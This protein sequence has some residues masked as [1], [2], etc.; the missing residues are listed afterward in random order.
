MDVSDEEWDGEIPEFVTKKQ[1]VVVGIPV[2]SVAVAA[3]AERVVKE[4]KKR[5]DESD[6]WKNP[7]IKEGK[8]VG[9]TKKGVWRRVP[10]FPKKTILVSSK[11]WV[12][13]W[14]KD[15]KAWGRPKRGT[16]RADYYLEIGLHGSLY[17]VHR[18][19]CR[20][21]RGAPPSR[22]HTTDHLAKYGDQRKERQDNRAENL[23]WKDASGQCN[24]RT[25]TGA[26][27]SDDRPLEVRSERA[28]AG[29]TPGEWTWFQSQGKAA[30]AMGVHSVSVSDWLAG[31]KRCSLGWRLR[32]APFAEPQDDLPATDEDPA[33][34]WVQVDATTR[35]SNHGR[36]EQPY[37][38]SEKKRKYTPRA[39]E[40]TG[41][42]PV[43]SVGGKP[44][45]YFHVVVFD[46][47]C[48]GV[49]G[50]RTVDHINR[51]PSDA[52]LSNLRPYTMAQQSRNRR[53]KPLGDGNQDSKKTRIQYRRADAPDDAPWQKCL[54]AHELA[55]RLTKTTKKTYGYTSISRASNG[56]YGKGACRNPHKYKD[57]VFYK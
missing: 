57:Y 47:H 16:E 48:P 49:R 43:I 8:R 12:M 44:N 17:L 56:T 10:G 11:G 41:G 2:A 21:F 28:R 54:G 38:K 29:W 22:E 1:K 52:R 23:D 9:K 30:E 20:A 33:E 46:A 5:Y 40:G 27:R 19:I 55:R 4:K 14:S 51:D 37:H 53:R 25:L 31:K 32:W 24:N 35:V 13:Q 15:Q 39:T 3:P 18:L 26:P 42:Y 34:V 7:A 45:L 50:D 6:D 36:A